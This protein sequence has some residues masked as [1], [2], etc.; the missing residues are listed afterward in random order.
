[1]DES[2]VVESAEL[3]VASLSGAGR[4]HAIAATAGWLPVQYVEVRALA[5]KIPGNL[6]ADRAVEVVER[7]LTDRG[8][9]PG[10][11]E[12]LR[13][14][15]NDLRDLVTTPQPETVED[16]WE[17]EAAESISPEEFDDEPL[18][19]DGP[20]PGPADPSGKNWPL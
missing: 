10:F 3:L 7:W 18:E 19:F 8:G 9:A 4:D 5:E 16:A 15:L 17:E 1:V 12:G 2:V 11:E 13:G 20:P 6:A 14:L